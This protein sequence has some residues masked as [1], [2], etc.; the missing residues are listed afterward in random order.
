ML[1]ER[2]KLQIVADAS[3]TWKTFCRFWSKSVQTLY[4]SALKEFGENNDNAK[5]AFPPR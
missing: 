3:N 1:S 2:D 4:K 5:T